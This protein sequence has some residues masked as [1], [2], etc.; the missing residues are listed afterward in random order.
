MLDALPDSIKERL[1]DYVHLDSG[2]NV[3]AVLDE[4]DR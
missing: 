1:V 2:A 4:I 3:Q